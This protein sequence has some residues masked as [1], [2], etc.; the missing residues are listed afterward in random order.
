MREERRCK[1]I[2]QNCIILQRLIEIL[3]LLARQNIALR[4][5]CENDTQNNR[6]NF[7]QFIDHQQNID[8]VLRE[9][10]ESAPKNALY[11]HHDV[12]D[13]LISLCAEDI[14]MQLL[15]MFSNQ[16]FCLVCVESKDISN[17]GQMAL[18]LRLFNQ[19]TISVEERMINLI[20]LKTQDANTIANSIVSELE[21]C[22]IN[23]HKCQGQTYDGA[24]T[25]AGSITG[26]QT[27]LRTIEPKATLTHCHAHA[28]NL[29]IVSSCTNLYITNM[30]GTLDKLH[31]FFKG[32]KR[33]SVLQ[34]VKT[35]FHFLLQIKKDACKVCRILDGLVERLQ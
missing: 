6:G 3:I 29:A 16:Y 20:P 23:I 4:G 2:T 7:L 21:N 22:G 25:M 1:Q 14:R 9:H 15:S 24:A 13:E 5:H 8:I 30:F 35:K 19:A 10:L 33:N 18:V 11:T 17:V 32:A 28:L 12:Q 31:I 34:D 27:Q 26:V